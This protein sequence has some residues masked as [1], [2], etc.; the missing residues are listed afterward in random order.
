MKVLMFAWEFPPLIS[1]GLGVACHGIVQA[2]LDKQ[3]SVRLVLPCV[4][5]E[6]SKLEYND[7]HPLLKTYFE[8]QLKVYPLLSDL[9]PYFIST[10]EKKNKGLGSLYNENLKDNVWQYAQEASQFADGDYDCIHAHEWLT[11]LAGVEAKKKS[12]KPLI[13]HVHALENDRNPIAPNPDIEW[14]EKLGLEQA[15]LVI[16]VSQYT[17]NKIMNQYH[18]QDEKIIVVHN[19]YSPI[20]LPKLEPSFLHKNRFTILFLGRIT[21]QKGL[22]YFIQAAKLI[23]D[24]RKDVDFI[25]A[26]VGDQLPY[27]I[28]LSASLG[29]SSHLHFVGFV[30]PNEV[31]KFYQISDVY[32]MPSVSEPFGIVCLEAIANGVPI[33]L[34]KQSGAS[35]VITHSFKVDYWDVMF[36]AE[37]IMALLDYPLIKEE[38]LKC[39]K[40]ELSRVTWDVAADK[41]NQ[42]YKR[43]L[44]L[45]LK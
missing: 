4:E 25:V 30:E 37:K 44:L 17:K 35:E 11:V 41:I 27:M 19:G 10:S 32:V 26:G 34:S 2:L 40:E 28:E 24:K 29:L 13:F 23:C 8:N 39:A 18:I 3:V 43:S 12:H 42:I 21:E 36:M 7:Q 6:M 45:N 20:D 38:M 9:N 1:G 33:V 15:D 14:I 5:K 16:A 22:Y 31:H